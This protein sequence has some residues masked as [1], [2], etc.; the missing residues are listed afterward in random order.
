VVDIGDINLDMVSNLAKSE[1][2]MSIE[3]Q[4]QVMLRIQHEPHENQIRF[5]W[6]L[7]YK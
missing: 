7:L 6:G 4:E 1:D 3:V 2:A 5:S